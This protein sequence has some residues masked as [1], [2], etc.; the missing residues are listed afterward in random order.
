VSRF[1]VIS[2]CSGGGKST[3]LATLAEQGHAVVAEPGR[4][5]VDEALQG[6]AGP[7]P[8]EDM[9]GFLHRAWS[10]ALA[11][12][13]AAAQHRGWVFFDRGLI[14]A[15]AGLAHHAGGDVTQWLGAEHRYHRQVFLTPPWPAIYT[16]DAARRHGLDEAQA[17]YARLLAAYTVLGYTLTILP[18]TDVLTR[19][20]TVL[21]TLGAPP[22]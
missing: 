18:K 21:E 2:G 20:N 19:V 16:A 12:R 1:V 15:A 22:G 5:I 11:D 3:L 8:W 17:E 6:G 14:D 7:L 13:E 4:R 9:T 10:L